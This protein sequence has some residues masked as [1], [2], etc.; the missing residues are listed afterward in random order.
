MLS[1]VATLFVAANWVSAGEKPDLDDPKVREKILKDA[2]EWKN[3]EMRGPDGG[4]LC[5]QAGKESSHGCKY[6][7]SFY[8][9][10]I[11]TKYE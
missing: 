4:K 3:L 8:H 1:L 7:K 11:S 6:S 5:Y 9:F 10:E 2:V